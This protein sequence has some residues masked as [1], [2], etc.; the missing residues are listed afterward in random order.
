MDD[1]FIDLIRREAAII[2]A[3]RQFKGTVVVTAYDKRKHALK[4]MLVPYMVETGWIPIGAGAIGNGSGDLMAPKVGSADALDGDQFAVQFDTGDTNTIV[5]THRIFSDA[6]APPQIEAGEMMRRHQ[7][8]QQLY[9]DKDGNA[10]LSRD[11]GSKVKLKASGDAVHTAK[12]GGIAYY[13]GD[14]DDGGTFD[15]ISTP[16]GP[17]TTAKARVG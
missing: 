13:G 1:G 10:T 2:V 14:P 5:A 16:S 4:G 15:W 7:D 17:S 8:G 11:D 12:P 6:D 3:Q 9:F